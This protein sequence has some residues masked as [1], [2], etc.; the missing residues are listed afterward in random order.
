MTHDPNPPDDPGWR[1]LGLGSDHFIVPDGAASFSDI[2]VEFKQWFSNKIPAVDDIVVV[3]SQLPRHLKVP[4]FETLRRVSPYPNLSLETLREAQDKHVDG[5]VLF[6]NPGSGTSGGG[7]GSGTLSVAWFRANAA[8]IPFISKTEGGF[9]SLNIRRFLAVA[10]GAIIASWTQAVT[11]G[12]SIIQDAL[13]IEPVDA[14]GDF[15][16]E[17][18]TL[19]S[20]TPASF[21]EGAFS[22]QPPEGVIAFPV[23]VAV[24][25]LGSY[26]L[27]KTWEVTFG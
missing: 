24:V 2:R 27:A 9:L 4:N 19:V 14:F 7:T 23:A 5:G 15:L 8:R 1:R 20:T 21:I 12:V 3:L 26:L 18:A 6:A 17:V 16:S 22:W 13:F 11:V 10:V 25:L